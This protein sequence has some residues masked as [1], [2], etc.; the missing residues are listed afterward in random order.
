MTS[1]GNI[2]QEH[3]EQNIRGRDTQTIKYPVIDVC[4][5]SRAQ[6]GMSD[7]REPLLKYNK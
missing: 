1:L 6:I 7:V 2:T 5:T 3:L 4:F